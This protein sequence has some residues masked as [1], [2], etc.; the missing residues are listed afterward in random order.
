MCEKFKKRKT[1]YGQVPPKDISDE[2]EPWK[3]IHIVLIGPYTVKAKQEVPRQKTKEVQL[4]PQA[5]TMT[6]PAT[7]WFEIAEVL[8]NDVGSARISQI[9]N[10]TWLSRYP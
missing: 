4:E 1:R 6:D 8:L 9:F 7:G 2:M 3:I 10:N 5:M